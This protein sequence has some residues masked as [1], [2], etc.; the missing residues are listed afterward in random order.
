[1]VS[2]DYLNRKIYKISCR[3]LLLCVSMIR[4]N[5]S[6]L[7]IFDQAHNLVSGNA[8]DTVFLSIF[9]GCWSMTGFVAS[10]DFLDLS[11]TPLG[12]GGVQL[13]GL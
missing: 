6:N 5:K 9:K 3:F 1:M 7:S 12:S 2:S 4:R 8:V 11:L 13:D 10:L